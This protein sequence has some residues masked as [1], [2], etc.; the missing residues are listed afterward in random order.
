MLPDE[1]LSYIYKPVFVK[2]YADAHFGPLAA[3]NVPAVAI[4]G[5]KGSLR[6]CHV[7]MVGNVLAPAGK[8]VAIAAEQ[9]ACIAQG[10]GFMREVIVLIH[11]RGFDAGDSA[12]LRV[13]GQGGQAVVGPVLVE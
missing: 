6:L 3:K 4:A 9:V 13:Q 2:A 10:R 5:H 7:G 1:N 12:K 8:L 11:I